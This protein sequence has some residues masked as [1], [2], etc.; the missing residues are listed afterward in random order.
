MKK[1]LII[2][3]GFILLVGIILGTQAL[4]NRSKESASNSEKISVVASFYPLGEF[5]RQ[6]GGDYVDVVV[7]TPSGVEPHDYEPTP[8]QIKQA[9]EADIF[10]FNGNGLDPWAD[11]VNESTNKNDSARIDMTSTLAS[12]PTDLNFKINQEDSHVWLDP[13]IVAV[14]IEIIRD[15]FI[16]KDPAHTESYN[17]NA[18]RY[19]NE[20]LSSLDQ[21]FRKQLSSCE[22]NTIIVSHDA[23]SYLA[24][25]YNFDTISISGISPEEEPSA[26]KIKELSDLAKEKEISTIFFETLVSPKF[27]ET[28]AREVGAQT[29]VLNPLE[30]LTKEEIAQGKNYVS[31]MEE[32]LNNLKTALVC[33]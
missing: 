33:K 14:Q 10:I 4:G 21:E 15:K 13:I 11:K 1:I 27:A 3:A 29:L 18:Q 23:F 26:Q 24:S 5:S 2:I 28:I 25:Q 30:G 7:V 20:E 8:Q 32:N 16:E 19:T 22:K 6:V 31:V 12:H 17:M 9:Q